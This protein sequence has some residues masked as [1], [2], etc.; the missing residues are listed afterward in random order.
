MVRKASGR[1]D[2]KAVVR[3]VSLLVLYSNV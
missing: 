2:D 1:A 3:P